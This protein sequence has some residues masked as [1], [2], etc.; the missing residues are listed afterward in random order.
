MS[1]GVPAGA[2]ARVSAV[3]RRGRARSTAVGGGLVLAAFAALCISLSVGDYTI[4]VPDVAAT[5]LGGGDGGTRFVVLELRLPRALLALLVGCC[6]GL[7][8]AVFQTLLRNPLASPDVIGVSSGAGAAVVLAG[9]LAGLSGTP[10]SFVALAGSLATGTAV[11]LLAWRKGVSGYR[12][13]LVGLGIG[14]GLTSVISY[15]MTRSEVTEAQT[16]FLWLAGSLNGR[17]WPHFWPLLAGAALLVPLTALAARALPALQLGDDTAGG[18]GARVERDRLA[19]LACATALAGVATAAAGPVGFVA[20]VSPP[21]AR[22]LVPGQGAALLPSA[23]TGALLVL[24]A[25]FTAQHLIPGTQLPVGIVTSVIGAP[26]LL[27]LLA[28]SNRAGQGG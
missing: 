3:R 4:P 12:L 25:D 18:L 7:S 16:A 1:G 21:I 13:V 23:A 24:V 26:Y 15:Q 28:R 9:G 5:L 8:G 20:F 17:S 11:Y 6:F 22:R 19:L 10:L 14:T 27:W 2:V